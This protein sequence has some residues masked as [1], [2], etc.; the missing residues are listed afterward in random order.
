MILD[1]SAGIATV[2]MLGSNAE[3]PECEPL[4]SDTNAHAQT[5]VPA[6]T[7]KWGNIRVES[8]TPSNLSTVAPYRPIHPALF[9]S[10]GYDNIKWPLSIKAFPSTEITVIK[11]N[12]FRK[13]IVHTRWLSYV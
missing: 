2:E 7:E 1:R 6:P 9:L 12:E 5:E 13:K 10:G 4:I 3:E 11:D 8:S